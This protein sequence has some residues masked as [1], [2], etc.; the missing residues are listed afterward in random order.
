MRFL[1]HK[2]R[3]VNQKRRD[4]A[5][6]HFIRDPNELE[7]IDKTVSGKVQEKP[8]RGYLGTEDYLKMLKTKAFLYG[9]WDLDRLEHEV[10][11]G[12]KKEA[13]A[14]VGQFNPGEKVIDALF[15]DSRKYQ[16]E[17]IEVKRTVKYTEHQ[18]KN[19]KG[20][21]EY[22]IKL[23]QH[24]GDPDTEDEEVKKVTLAKDP[25]A[26]HKIRQKRREFFLQ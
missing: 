14:Y 5:N 11:T 10:R 20:V 9:E 19:L 6:P 12:V 7:L 18:Q 23:N 13:P 2:P 26:V 4:D 1:S 8:L 16:D 3:L 22:L 15:A 24:G 25:D 17:I 21:D